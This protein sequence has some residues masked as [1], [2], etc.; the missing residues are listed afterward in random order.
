MHWGNV[1]CQRFSL[2]KRETKQKYV[3]LFI[4]TSSLMLGIQSNIYM[5]SCF[6]QLTAKLH[7]TGF[8]MGF[9]TCGCLVDNNLTVKKKLA[10]YT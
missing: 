8:A 7:V 2:E 1:G 6:L 4:M 10:H 3:S 9:R 5:F